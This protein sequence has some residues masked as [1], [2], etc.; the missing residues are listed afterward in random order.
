MYDY[1]AHILRV[2]D[3]DTVEAN[4]DVGFKI[5][6]HT[7]VRLAGLN[8]PEL[9]Q[10][11][12]PIVKARL[13][14]LVMNKPNTVIVSK[15]LDKYGRVLGTIYVDGVSINQQLIDEKLAIRM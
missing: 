8:A 2:I 1:K 4:I 7:N 15:S 3:G 6:Y 13:I 5:N 10:P 12:G 9:N 14:E 11:D